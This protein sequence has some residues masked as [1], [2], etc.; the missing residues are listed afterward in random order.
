MTAMPAATC[1]DCDDPTPFAFMD[2]SGVG[3]WKLGDGFNTT[4]DTAH[5]VCFACAKAWKQRLSGPL[6]P[7]IVG[8]LAFFTCRRSG[9]DQALAVTRESAVPT[10]IELACPQGHRHAVKPGDGDG[11]VLVEV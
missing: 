4:P 5:Y 6:T 7:D 11:L 1:P 3:A 10:D 2:T 9:C 8:D